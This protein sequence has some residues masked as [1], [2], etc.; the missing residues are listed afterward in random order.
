[1]QLSAEISEFTELAK[2]AKLESVKSFLNNEVNRLNHKK[3][4]L[5]MEL[6]KA[7]KPDSNLSSELGIIPVTKYMWDQGSDHVKIYIEV[8]KNQVIDS[9]QLSLKIISKNGF[10]CVFGKYR[11]TI[12]RLYKEVDE[13]KSTVKITKSNRVVITLYKKTSE[14]WPSLNEKDNSFKAP[15]ADDKDIDAD[16]SAGLMKLMKN[17][18]DEGDD[19]MKRTIA[20]SWYDA[21]SKK[22]TL[23]PEL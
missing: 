8:D 11:L 1:M 6:E 14:N 21:Q 4:L 23:D 18:Y 17:M 5:E 9:S 20:K 10:T 3:E 13:N 16:P 12:S 7:L 2:L 15:L 19:E 22:T